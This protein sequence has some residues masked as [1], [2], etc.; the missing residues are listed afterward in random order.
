MLADREGLR[1]QKISDAARGKNE[2]VLTWEVEYTT[3]MRRSQSSHHSIGLP[4]DTP[5]SPLQGP[6]S[7][8]APILGQRRG[9]TT[10]LIV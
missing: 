10:T 6:T 1:E 3:E 2:N 7:A 9:D 5:G 4:R 8:E